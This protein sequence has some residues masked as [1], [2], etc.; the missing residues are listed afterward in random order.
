MRLFSFSSVIFFSLNYFRVGTS[1]SSL[2]IRRKLKTN[3]NI[4]LI[5]LKLVRKFNTLLYDWSRNSGN[6]PRIS[7][8]MND[9]LWSTSY[10]NNE[11]TLENKNQSRYT[12]YILL[13]HTFRKNVLTRNMNVKV[14]NINHFQAALV[15]RM[16]CNACIIIHLDWKSFVTKKFQKYP[17]EW[18]HTNIR[19]NCMPNSWKIVEFFLSFHLSCVTYLLF[20]I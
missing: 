20:S 9:F 18:F 6:F 12:S 11:S 5:S 17:I 7:D 14:F 10:K 3:N 8:R 2:E 13:K 4:S 15:A 1:R 19:T 16:F